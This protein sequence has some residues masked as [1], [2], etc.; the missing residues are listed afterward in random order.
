M[1]PEMTLLKTNT[2]ILFT[3]FRPGFLFVFLNVSTTMKTLI[4]F[5]LGNLKN[6]KWSTQGGGDLFSGLDPVKDSVC[7]IPSLIFL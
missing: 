5:P 7:C 4:F 6:Q 3:Y 1:R 2:Y